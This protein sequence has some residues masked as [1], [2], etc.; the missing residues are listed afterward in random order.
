[1][2]RYLLDTNIS[3]RVAAP[4]SNHHAVAM[5]AIGRLLSRG[6]ELMLAPQVL[7]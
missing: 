6:N 1:M 4:K 3:L 2:A 7:N 5:Q